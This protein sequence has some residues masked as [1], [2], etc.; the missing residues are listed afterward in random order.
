MQTGNEEN[1]FMAITKW[2]VITKWMIISKWMVITKGGEAHGDDSD[3][4]GVRNLG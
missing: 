2:M 4:D 3:D 1:E